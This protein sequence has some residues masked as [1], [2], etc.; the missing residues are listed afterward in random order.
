[1]KNAY[2]TGAVIQYTLI[3]SVGSRL[4]T[5]VW[6]INILKMLMQKPHSLE[7]T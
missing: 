3:G 6:K 5:L 2:A 1:M 7:V 4:D